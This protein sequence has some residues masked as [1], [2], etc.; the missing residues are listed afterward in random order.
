MIKKPES[1]ISSIHTAI[2]TATADII[3]DLP[4]PITDQNTQAQSYTHLQVDIPYI[5]IK[6]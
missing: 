6:S 1:T 3:R 4:V 5:G 2:Y